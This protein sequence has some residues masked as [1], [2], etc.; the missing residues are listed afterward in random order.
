MNNSL[1]KS[2]Y[3]AFEILSEYIDKLKIAFILTT[4]VGLM[5]GI[6]KSVAFVLSNSY[7]Q[8]EMYYLAIHSTS[9]MINNCLLISL[10]ALIALIIV[11]TFL[12]FISVNRRAS[13]IIVCGILPSLLIFIFGGYWI[14]KLYLP[15]FF[16]TKSI[17]GNAVWLFTCVLSGWLIFKIL[18]ARSSFVESMFN[19]KVLA[20]VFSLVIA[21]NV[22]NYFYFQPLEPGRPNLILILRLTQAL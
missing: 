5:F 7:L 13:D 3:E 2:K 6:L 18:Q 16:E 4:M 10:G 1:D 14:N 17:I 21:L 20:A 8:L 12:N 11:R 9:S 22:V 15:G 19:A